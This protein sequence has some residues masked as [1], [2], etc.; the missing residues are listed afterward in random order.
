MYPIKVGE[1]SKSADG[2]S[3]FEKV[4]NCIIGHGVDIGPGVRVVGGKGS[5]LVIGDYTKIHRDTLLMPRNSL[6]IGECCW[7]GERCVIDGTG[8]TE[9]KDFVGVGINSAL[10]SHIQ[11]GDILEGSA[12]NETGVLKVGNDVWLVGECLVGPVVIG[13]KA[14]AML[15]SVITKDMPEMTTW[16]GNPARDISDKVR[17][18]WQT[19]T[20][21]DKVDWL[22]YVLMNNTVINNTADLNW[23]IVTKWPKYPLPNVTYYN[24]ATREYTKTGTKEEYL[25]NKNIFGYKCRFRARKE[26]NHDPAI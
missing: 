12:Y 9:I 24:V 8:Y 11:H 22:Y 10:Y 3:E 25:R 20:L 19:R 6:H 2:W 15:G 4:E 21:E 23:Q 1:Y 5:T 14:M 26:E 18:P 17:L 16:G 7:F 13:D